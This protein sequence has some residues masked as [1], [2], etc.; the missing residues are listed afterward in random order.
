MKYFWELIFW[1]KILTSCFWALCIR[2]SSKNLA[3]RGRDPGR[4]LKM[5]VYGRAI[6]LFETLSPPVGKIFLLLGCHME[7]KDGRFRRTSNQTFCFGYNARITNLI[8]YWKPKF[9]RGQSCQRCK[10]REPLENHTSSLRPTH[11][12]LGLQGLLLQYIYF[13]CIIKWF[14]MP[15]CLVQVAKKEGNWT[16][17]RGSFGSDKF[18]WLQATDTR[19]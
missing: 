19:L 13:N 15:I 3:L 14:L 8:I 1:D 11:L 7:K 17:K 5:M 12:W 6:G 2:S 10:T 16:W 18:G 4:P 9:E